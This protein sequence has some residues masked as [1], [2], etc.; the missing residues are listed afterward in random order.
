MKLDGINFSKEGKSIQFNGRRIFRNNVA[1]LAKNNPYSLTEPNQR[2]ITNSI[3][4][5]AKVRDFRNINFLLSTAAK[6]KYSTNIE[7][8]TGPKNPWKEILISAAVAAASI[9]PALLSDELIQKI[10]D[11]ATPSPLNKTEKSI[12]NLRKQLLKKVDL[13]QINNETKGS[14]KNF[15]TNLDTFITS[16]ETTQEHKKYV[17]E[18]LNYLMSE[19]YEINPQLTNKKSIVVAEMIND[20]A[21][22]TS[23]NE[24][25]NIKLVNQKQHGMCAAISIVRKKIAYEDKPNYVDSILSELDASD[26]ISVYDRNALGTGKKVEVSKIRVDFDTAIAKGYRI[27]DAST[28]HWMQIAQMSGESNLAYNE[29]IPFDKENFD[30]KT[31]NFLNVKIDDPELEKAQNYYQALI[32]AKSLIKDYKAD[33]LKNNEIKK[34]SRLAE[35]SNHETMGKISAKIRNILTQIEPNLSSSELNTITAELLNLEKPYSNK[36]NKDDNFSYIP[37]EEEIMKEGKVKSFLEKN[38]NKTLSKEISSKI[39]NLVSYYNSL[40]NETTQSSRKGSVLRKNEELYQIAAAFR[41][42]IVRSLEEKQTLDNIMVAEKIPSKEI[43]ILNHIDT[44]IEKLETES[45]HTELILEQASKAFS[46]DA[47]LNAEDMAGALRGLKEI[48]RAHV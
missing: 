21:F 44:L 29:Y 4:E 2:L 24:Y 12:L 7:L 48:G 34:N 8:K 28:M 40:A 18:R 22:S 14:I 33:L 30:V 16:S 43:L 5:L 32:M 3:A 25:P 39:Y 31:D 6:N 47:K 10:K 27:I 15:E 41:Y 1:Q 9:T 38:L 19:K 42:Q 26:Y 17:L 36:I 35:N 23:D 11:L 46:D 20:M 37:N 45:P 13:E